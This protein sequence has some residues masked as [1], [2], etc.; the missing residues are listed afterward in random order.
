[1][2]MTYD[3]LWILPVLAFTL[4]PVMLFVIAIAASIFVAVWDWLW[5]K[6]DGQNH[7]AEK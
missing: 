1:M 6:I 2:T 4:V 3:K 7:K 5:E